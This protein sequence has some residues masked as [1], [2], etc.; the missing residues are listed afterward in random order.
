MRRGRRPGGPRRAACTAC[1]IAACA[2]GVTAHEG[3]PYPIIS[4][5]V[6]GAY[7][8]SL[9]TD[10][11]TTDDGSPGGQFWVMVD[12]AA[13][14]GPLPA[15]TRANVAVTPLGHAGPERQAPAAPVGGEVTRQ[16]AA[17]VLDRE[18][19]FGVRVA[20]D[21]PWGPAE[22]GADVEATYDLRPEPILLAVYMVP[23]LLAGFL[24]LKLLGRRR[25]AAR[26]SQ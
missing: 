8:I 9:W 17:L 14:S 19:R 21:G 22:V 26:N 10:P 24:W 18:G 7:R 12:P 3:P 16:F 25:A 6:A 13:A 5:E 23:F 15:G 20:I 11:D 2:M 1:V 4:N